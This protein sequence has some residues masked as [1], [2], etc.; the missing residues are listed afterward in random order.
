V[1]SP[2]PEGGS[3]AGPGA[4]MRIAILHY[5]ALPV[6]GG[7]ERV[8][9][10]HAGLMADAGHSVTVVAGRGEQ[11][12]PRVAFLRLPSADSADAGILALRA[13]L[14]AGIVPDGFAAA[15]EALRRDLGA[16][17]AGHA[18]V[19][20]HNVCSLPFNLALTAALR[21][22]A[23]EPGAPRLVAWHHDLAWTQPRFRDVLHDGDPW[24]LLRTAWPGV[25]HVAV[26]ETR[27]TELA[28]LLRLAPE[29]VRVVR[30]GIDIEREL[31][32][33][34]AT[35]LHVTRTGMLD[36]DPLLLLPARVTPRK[37]IEL[38]L[39]VVAAMRRAGRAAGL[40]VTG[41]VDPHDPAQREYLAGLLALRRD[42]DLDAAAWFLAAESGEPLADRVVTD[43]YRVA[44]ALLLPSREEGFGLPIL[45]AALHRL[46]IVCTDLP[47]LREVA[48]EGAT[49]LDPDADPDEA[50]R[51]V[52]DR[53]DADSEDALWRRVRREYAW[54]A[55]YRERIEPLL[56]EL[57]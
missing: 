57:A 33:D 32:L 25:R 12:D 18:V 29:N 5:S 28:G 51:V 38:G 53:L 47:V 56:A 52:L 1:T 17:L 24:D 4:R 27:R 2:E 26:S 42:L 40:V 21:R 49:Y 41:P 30:N 55:V 10:R 22:L 16:A 7:V 15:V 31:D 54:P 3:Q 13:A 34:P 20:A 35:A 14:D 44:D 43:L 36:A 9:G 8:I 23:S 39:R 50:A 6:V 46:P 48:G 37:N 45:E 11:Q 19:I